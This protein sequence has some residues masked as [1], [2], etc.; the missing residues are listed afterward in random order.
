[1][2][3]FEGKKAVFAVGAK[4]AE[5]ALNADIQATIVTYYL[6]MED[7]KALRE[8]KQNGLRSFAIIAKPK[9]WHSCNA[10]FRS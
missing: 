4:Q 9:V 5:L 8:L 2:Q 7:L 3:K 1:M 10:L 6:K